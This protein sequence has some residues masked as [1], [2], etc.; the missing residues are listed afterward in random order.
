MYMK[1]HMFRRANMIKIAF[2][3]FN[4]DMDKYFSIATKDEVIVEIEENKSV[5][6]MSEKEYEKLKDNYKRQ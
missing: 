1:L 2:D 6:V 4:K 5:V 3:E